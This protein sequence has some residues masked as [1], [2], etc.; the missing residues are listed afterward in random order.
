MAKGMLLTSSTWMP[1]FE[2]QDRSLLGGGSF[3]M[4]FRYAR[5]PCCQ[6]AVG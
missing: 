3:G 5:T 1:C 6:D 2:S 4:T